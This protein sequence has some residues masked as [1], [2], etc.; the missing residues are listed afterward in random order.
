MLLSVAHGFNEF[1]SIIIPPLFPIFATELGMGYAES[2][3]FVVVYFAVYSICQMPV[4]P[5]AD[6]YSRRKILVVGLMILSIGIAIVAFA[7]SLPLMLIGMGIAGIGGSTYHP[8][9]MAL[10]SDSETSKTHGRSMGIHGAMGSLGAVIAPLFVAGIA[11]VFGWRVGLLSGGALGLLFAVVLAIL[12]PRVHPGEKNTTSLREAI[13]TII[14]RASS[15]GDGFITVLFS[16]TVLTLS[17]L[18][19]VVGAE[20]RAIQTFTV[21]FAD[22]TT[23]LGAG[24]GSTLLALTMGSAGVAS[25]LA[26]YVV[27]RVDRS[28]FLL[29]CF[30]GTACTVALLVLVGLPVLVFSAGFA[31]L[32][33]ILYSVYPAANAIA[34]G[35]SD[36]GSSGS[37]FAVMNTAGAVGS[38]ASPFVMGLIADHISISAAF[39]STTGLALF[40]ALV[41]VL[42]KKI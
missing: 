8:T 20:V 33:L 38:A 18:F 6:V 34:A 35:A 29:I 25:I 42:S 14:D 2:S 4:G 3:L 21:S 11:G 26:G 5:L 15:V 24:Y 30:L 1:F 7:E 17:G 13:R 16:P 41:V 31:V 27:D 32:G 10:I 22:V 39:L 12:Y 36:E 37:L 19:F 23:G 9:G 28:R 40:G